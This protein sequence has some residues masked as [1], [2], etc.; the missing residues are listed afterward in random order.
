MDSSKALV[1]HN[2]NDV[3]PV[4]IQIARDLKKLSSD[5]KNGQKALQETLD[6]LNESSLKVTIERNRIGLVKKRS[7]EENLENVYSNLSDYVGICGKA[8]QNTNENL[9][10]ALD[11]IKLLALVEKD[12]YEH[13][14][15]QMVSNNELK[16]ILLDWFE[17]QG[18]SDNEVRELLES[19]FQRA[20][21]LRDRLNIFRQEYKSSIATCEKRLLEFESKYNSL[22]TEIAKLIEDSGNKL[23]NALNA[24]INL[25]SQ[26][27]KEKRSSLLSLY[28]EHVFLVKKHEAETKQ[29]NNEFVQS[30]EEARMVVCHQAELAYRQIQTANHE[31]EN[32]VEYSIDKLQKMIDSFKTESE[33]TKKQQAELFENDR[34]KMSVKLKRTITWTVIASIS[35]STALSYIFS[36]LL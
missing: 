23:Q 27:Y 8:L 11:L 35:L 33:E 4:G 31:F 29:L 19:S 1:V 17:K 10:R 9:S 3:V 18:I 26:L 13:L 34:K 6:K 7:V 36:H 16:N 28:D 32:H 25:L 24:A 30:C 14:D 2:S 21:T 22:D 20:Y 5:I 12:L 15:D